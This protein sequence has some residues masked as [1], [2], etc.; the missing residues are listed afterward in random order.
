[1]T[2]KFDICVNEACP[3]EFGHE[4]SCAT[5]EASSDT[6]WV[7]IDG[8]AVWHFDLKPGPPMTRYEIACLIAFMQT[9]QQKGR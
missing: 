3:L 2:D 1:M 8:K 5:F 4:G 7:H 9:M 6:I